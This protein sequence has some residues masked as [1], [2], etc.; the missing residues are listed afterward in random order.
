MT[1][2]FYWSYFT[3]TGNIEAYMLYAQE[4]GA[5]GEV[6]HTDSFEDAGMEDALRL[7]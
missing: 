2:D 1:R 6:Q 3:R 5:A 4:M 7:P